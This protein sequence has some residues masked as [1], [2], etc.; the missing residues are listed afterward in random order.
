MVT[1]NGKAF[2][3][4]PVLIGKRVQIR[5]D[6]AGDLVRIHVSHDGKDYGEARPLNLYANAKVKRNHDFSGEMESRDSQAPG[7]G[8]LL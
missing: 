2:E 5:F 6:P 1:I 3:V 8:G 7:N 4:P